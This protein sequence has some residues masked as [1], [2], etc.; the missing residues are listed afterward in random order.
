MSK[1]GEIIFSEDGHK[2]PKIEYLEIISDDDV[3]YFAF[4]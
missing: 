1:K 2:C 3:S 4:V